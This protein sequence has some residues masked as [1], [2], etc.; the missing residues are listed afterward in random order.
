MGTDDYARTVLDLVN[1]RPPRLGRRTRLLCIDGPAGSGKSTL[2]AAVASASPVATHVLPLDLLLDGWSGL[3]DVV[4][5]LVDE[6]LRPM[7][8]GRRATH[9]R[10]DWHEGRFV[11]RVEVPD[12]ALLVVE[13]VGAGSRGTQPYRSASVWLDAPEDVRRDRALSREGDGDA[14]APHWA[15]WAAREARLFAREGTRTTADLVLTTVR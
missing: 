2:A 7:S 15:A 9:R 3:D 1:G 14:F 13:G 6:V 10:Y 8:R 11:D 12:C 4:E 5:T